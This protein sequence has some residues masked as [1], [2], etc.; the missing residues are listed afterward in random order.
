MSEIPKNGAMLP[1]DQEAIRAKCFLPTGIFVEFD[2]EEIEQTIPERFEKIVCQ[3]PDRVAVEN[4]VH[5]FS[6][7]NLNRM[8]NWVA[9]TLLA[10]CDQKEK[11]IALLLETDVPLITAILGVLKAGKIYVP[12]DSSLP[13]A[14]IAYILN[15]AEVSL[16]ITN[17]RNLALARELVQNKLPLINL[18]ELDPS[19]PTENPEISISPDMLTWI[20]YTSGS[21]GLPKGVVQNHRNVLQFVKNYTNGLHICS[22]DRLTLLFSGSANGAAHDT[23]SALLNGAALYPFNVKEKSPAAMADWL[24]QNQL[25]IYCSVPTVFRHFLE[26]MT[27]EE[28]FPNL[29][30]IK[31]IGEPVSKRDVELYRGHF[32]ADCIFVNRF[33]STETGT[34][35]W[36]F[37]NKK[38]HIEGNIVPVGY[39]GDENEI[40][41]LDD[42]GEEVAAE[43]VGEIVVKSRYLTPGYWHKPDLTSGVL[44]STLGGERIY[45]TGDIGRLLPDGQ[46]LCLGRKDSQVKIRG[47]RVEIA[48]IEMAL[49]NL[50][51]VKAAVVIAW[52]DRPDNLHLVAYMTAKEQPPP[53][54]T[55]LRRA[56][57]ATLPQHMIPSR[58]VFLDVFPS[59]PN[60]KIDRKALPDPDTCRPALETPYT[61]ARTSIE[62]RIAH[63]WAAVLEVDQVG[64][65][66]NFFDLGGHSL[67]AVRLFVE[68]EKTFGKKL[69]L[70][71]LFQAPTIEQLA[72]I[73]REEER[74]ETQSSLWST[75]P[76]SVVPFQPNGSKPPLFWFNWG[77][78]DF[79]L[80]RY[81]G[82]DQPVYGLQHQSQDGHRARYTSIEEM[83]AHYI[84]EIRAVQT[85]GPYFLG[86]LCIGGMVAFEMAQ[87]LLEQGQ[88]VALL[89]LLDPSEPRSENFSSAHKDVP[90]LSSQI[91]W[92]RNKLNRH[93]HELAP[94]GPEEKLSYALVRVN[95]RIM[96]LTEKISWFGRRVSCEFF[97]RPLPLSFRSH[98]IVS[99]YKRASRAYVP[100]LYRRQVIL[101]KTHGRYRNGQSAWENLVADG[102]ETHELDIDH[103]NVF[104]EPYVRSFAE[105]LKTHLY[106]AQRNVQHAGI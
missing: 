16:L 19:L 54:V 42:K 21:T 89:V 104:K 66:D 46:L 24:I 62:E 43:A 79:R 4:D 34:I 81:L 70:A 74:S 27:G 14:R 22:D 98:Y 77:P 28:S 63:I 39:P 12:L 68:I 23:F 73:L 56:L 102:L 57:A 50:D 53:T 9:Y 25:T 59:A 2:K 94:L 95:G 99:I 85:Q 32:S 103:D 30:L 78:W 87:Q 90:N 49:I 37:I 69:P 86:G 1:P 20:L 47:H 55:R 100:Q 105:R 44:L 91:T 52:E 72:N 36:Y 8:A 64:V 13:Q 106:E 7:E 5:E 80:P 84:K 58:F 29:R 35:R 61:A 93:L 71:I 3:Y 60:G 75:Y 65:C 18:D 76:S 101:F 48:E 11:P 45:R 31:L 17:T 83:A 96:G 6:Y 51:L 26:T 40:L 15:D 88:E 82:S 38:T 97:R 33:G 41:L 10:R 92:F 67:L